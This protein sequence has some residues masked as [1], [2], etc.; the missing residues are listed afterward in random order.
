MATPQQNLQ[1]ESPNFAPIAPLLRLRDGAQLPNNKIADALKS[2]FQHF[3]NKDSGAWREILNVGTHVEL[4]LAGQQFPIRNPLDGSWSAIPLTGMA[5]TNSKRRALNIMANYYANLESKWCNSNPDILVRP[6]RNLDECAIAAKG[7]QVV[8]DFYTR[9]YYDVWYNRQECRS[10][11]TFGTYLNRIRYDDTVKSF[12]QVQ[13]IMG[14]KS[15]PFGEGMGYCPQC[16]FMGPASQ[17]KQNPEGVENFG[18]NVGQ[19]PEC[20]QTAFVEPPPQGQFQS[21]TGT[22]K[23][24]YGEL[25]CEQLPL[26]ACRWDLKKRAEDS[27]WFIYRQE[28]S[29]GAVERFLGNVKIPGEPSD[30]QGGMDGLR[31]I[32]ML[33]SGGQA[34]GGYG[35]YANWGEYSKYVKDRVSF[36]EMWLG[37]DEI[38]DINLTGGEETVSG[39]SLPQGKLV[40]LFPNGLC[41]VGLNGMAVILGLY[42][43]SHKEHISSG[44]WFIKGLSG[45]GRGLAD[46][47][48]VQKQ[49]NQFANQS[50]QYFD[51]IGTPALGVNSQILPPGRARYIGTP[52]MNIPFDM[53]KLP[54][55]AKLSDAIWQFQAAPLPAAL[56][57]Y[58]Q[59]FLNVVGQKTSGVTDYNQGEPGIV[60]K[61]Q[62][63]TAAEI[64]QSN[65]D[66]LNQPIF[67][68]KADVR[69]SNAEITLRMYPRHFPMKRYLHISGKFGQQQGR[70]LYGRDLQADLICEVV[71]NSEMPKG[72]FTQRKNLSTLFQI[73]GGGLG[74]SQ[75]KEADPKLAANL[76]QT[77]DVEIDSDDYEDVADLCRKRLD[78]MKQTAMIGVDDPM[79]LM[80]AIQPPIDDAEPNLAQ[81]AKWFSEIL[82]SDELQ[83]AP[84]GLRQACSLL[85]K[86]QTI[87][88]IQQ[89]M[90]LAT[91]QGAIEASAQAPQAIGEQMLNQGQQQPE[92][93]SPDTVISAQNDQANREVELQKMQMQQAHESNMSQQQ[94]KQNLKE[95]AADV[96]GKMAIAKAKPKATAK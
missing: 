90:A 47:V 13:N 36:D 83:N 29:K 69:R 34:I 92:Q 56:V 76:V 61:N 19:C 22:E 15:V 79:A 77:F 20:Q 74:Y 51:S 52:N 30:E 45:A 57:Q 37:P 21:L 65:A 1:P 23:K 14:A 50:A 58:Y 6:G 78:Q 95:T 54:D 60:G 12:S 16:D 8:W 68:G 49:V 26:A 3:Q 88:Q 4:F 72:P 38:A 28:I 7:G 18:A 75:L 93:P 5:N 35:S 62:T 71:T 33:A 46:S 17:F 25:V 70:E 43:E 84:M 96:K 2:K 73:T 10:A 94:H 39:Q 32:R 59:Q 91:G 66:V 41:C 53:T 67:Q 24:D 80:S 85:A 86:G 31:V 44:V 81:K 82:D 27:S 48:E 11:T 42:N 55:G 63:A 89:Q 40:D 64:D 9:R 87:G